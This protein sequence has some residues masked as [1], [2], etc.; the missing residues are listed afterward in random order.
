MV[1]VSR[2][3]VLVVDDDPV[4]RRM[5]QRTLELARFNV[6]VASDGARGLELLRDDPTIGL[7]LLD[8]TMPRMDGWKFLRA[9][10]ADP[11][12]ALI[13]TVIVSGTALT[14][15][16]QRELQAVDY[17]VKPVGREQLIAIV[18]AYCSPLQ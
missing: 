2:N 15:V 5:F 12:L 11:Q 6:A 9:Q 17:V 7:V 16:A 18:T 8:L 10:R 3:R 1:A 13:P 14:S 4:V